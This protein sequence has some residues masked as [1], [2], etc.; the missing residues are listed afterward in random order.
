MTMGYGWGV[1]DP[2]GNLLSAAEGTEGTFFA[3]LVIY[4]ALD[5]AFAGFTN[6]GNGSAALDEAIGRITGFEWNGGA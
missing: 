5:L 6:C 2:E 1:F 3:R 4:P